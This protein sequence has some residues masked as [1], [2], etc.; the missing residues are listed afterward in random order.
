ML[1][2]VSAS[3]HSAT[4]RAA[5]AGAEYKTGSTDAGSPLG[6]L[7]PSVSPLTQTNYSDMKTV[8]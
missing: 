3:D 2:A 6:L 1:S 4:E 7:S 5:S 8:S